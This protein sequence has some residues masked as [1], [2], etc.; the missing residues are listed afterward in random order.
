M[1]LPWDA[2]AMP[3]DDREYE[4]SDGETADEG[5]QLTYENQVEPVACSTYR[6]LLKMSP[7]QVCGCVIVW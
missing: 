3:T 7:M 6:K 5:S 2:V 1:E 4:T